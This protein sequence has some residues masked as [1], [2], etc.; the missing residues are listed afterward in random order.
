[1]RRKCTD[2]LIQWKKNPDRKPL[3]LQGGRQTGKTWLLR[4]FG[5]RHYETTLYVNLETEQTAAEYL[6]TPREADEALLFLETYANKSIR[7]SGTLVILDNIQCV[8]NTS[9]LLTAISLDYPGYHIA[10]IER[11]FSN[12]YN[13]YDIFLLHLF[14][15]DFEEFLWANMEFN[16]AKEIR[17]H[18]SRKAPMGKQLHEKAMAQFRLYLAI[19]GIPAAIQEYRKEKKLL[20]V[21]DIQQK[22]L[23]LLQADIISQ[24]PP[25]FSR[26]SRNCWLSIPSQLGK[27]NSKFQ[28]GQITKSGTARLYQEPLKWLIRHGL[29][30]HSIK[31]Q[32][33]LEHKDAG[34]FRMYYTDT[35]LS[36]CHLGIPA[37]ILLSGE[38][39]SGARSC[40]ETFLAQ[41]FVQNGYSLSYWSSGN[42]AEVPFLLEKDSAFTGVDYRL[43]PHQ[44]TRNLARL[45][46]M[47]DVDKMYLISTEDFKEKEQYEIVPFYAVFCI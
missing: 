2:K 3:V 8:P 6:S 44:K 36:V 45:N 19:G 37:Y 39:T 33:T 30:Y 47:C 13:N 22:I 18:F 41:H 43:S 25:E 21:P 27:T 29:A 15:L 46:T 1:M 28:Y 20:M 17:S 34:S 32:E 23:A 35:G 5:S 31:R 12:F 16:L 9:R 10:A 14:P 24:A 4:D 7:Q 11:G 40:I 26:H 38:E 42:Q